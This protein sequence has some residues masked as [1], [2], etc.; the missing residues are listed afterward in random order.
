MRSFSEVFPIH[1]PDIKVAQGYSSEW[2]LAALWHLPGQRTNRQAFHQCQLSG[3]C[4]KERKCLQ[5]LYCGHFSPKT[6]SWWMEGLPGGRERERGVR[7][8]KRNYKLPV[9]ARKSPEVPEVS[10]YLFSYMVLRNS[11]SLLMSFFFLESSSTIPAGNSDI[12]TPNRAPIVKDKEAELS[13]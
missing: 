3:D 12:Q 10:V 8:E 6:L 9:L 4:D 13:R 5:M 11:A 1:R 7:G 2:R